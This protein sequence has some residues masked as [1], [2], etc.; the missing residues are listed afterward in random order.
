MQMQTSRYNW[1][2][3][4]VYG[5]IDGAV[6]TFAIV[7]GVV[8]ANLS[9]KTILV[10][11]FANLIADGFSM[12]MGKYASDQAERERMG[13]IR[14]NEEMSILEKPEEER[15]ELR[16][17]L[18]QFGFRGADLSRAQNIIT[19]NPEAWVHLMLHH[20]F[21]IVE[22]NIQPVKGAMAT[23]SAFFLIGLVPLMSYLLGS[24]L[25]LSSKTMFTM[26]C[27]GTVLA[28]F[29]VGL[30]KSRFT[31]QAWW[32]AGLETSAVGAFAAGL[33]Y[34]IGHGLASL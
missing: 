34:W 19:K 24:I 18:N 1:L 9:L 12:A 32:R 10:L 11:G 31:D 16:Q 22:E 14:R 33:A 29:L 2:P 4:F 6:T 17:I 26:A 15:E 27:V 13:S 20:E 21:H 7:A 25:P 28:L 3:D 30:V 8:G 5:G 23:F